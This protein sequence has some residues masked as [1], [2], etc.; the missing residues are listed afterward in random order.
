[1]VGD[2]SVFEFGVV[3]CFCG[4]EFG[5]EVVGLVIGVVFLVGL[6]EFELGVGWK[7]VLV[8]GGVVEG[9]FIVGFGKI[10]SRVFGEGD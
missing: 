2:G 5:V 4:F 7:E 6:V 1:M 3:S 10:V 9:F 8:V